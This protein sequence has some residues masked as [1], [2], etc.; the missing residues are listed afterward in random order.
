VAARAIA[1]SATSKCNILAYLIGIIRLL[2]NSLLIPDF[3]KMHRFPF[4]LLY[5]IT[6]EKLAS[7]DCI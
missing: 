1:P 5:I 3:D 4:S 2:S 7:Y 6:T